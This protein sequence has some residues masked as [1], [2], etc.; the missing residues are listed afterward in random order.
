MN[1]NLMNDMVDQGAGQYLN[2]YRD[3]VEQLE[4][5]SLL[6]KVRSVRSMDI[7]SMGKQLDMWEHYVKMCEDDGS[8]SQLG[9]IP[10]IALDV[11]AASY[12]TNPL[13]VI[14]TNQPINEEVGLVYFKK[15]IA[16]SSRGSVSAGDTLVDPTNIQNTVTGFASDFSTF[17]AGTTTAGTKAYQVSL[18]GAPVRPGSVNVVISGANLPSFDDSEG[19][20]LGRG[21]SGSIDYAHG[22]VSIVLADDPADGKDISVSYATDFELSTDIPQINYKFTSKS[23]TARVYALKTT[24]GLEQQYA[25]RQRFGKIADEEAATDLVGQ[26]NAETMNVAI[27]MLRASSGVDFSWDAKADS[28]VSQHEHKLSFADQIAK[29]D[30]A[31]VGKSGRGAANILVC[32]RSS[33]AIASTLPGFVKLT[34]GSAHGP[35]IFGNLN[36]TLIIRVLMKLLFRLVKS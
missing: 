30:S 25:L 12:G 31:I 7:Y 27:A 6:S 2:K 34:D 17:S 20:L 36:G 13:S 23:L 26:I 32:G 19:N 10:A 14:A 29:L 35:H 3:L 16:S 21:I 11:I 15:L 9:K 24:M 33:S 1:E 8:V 18:P 5:H 22:V 4:S 28:G